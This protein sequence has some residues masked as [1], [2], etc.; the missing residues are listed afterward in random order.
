M[1]TL[2]LSAMSKT[3][4]KK[5]FIFFGLIRMADALKARAADI[6][7]RADEHHA[8]LKESNRALW[9]MIEAARGRISSAPPPGPPPPGGPP[10]PAGPPPGPQQ[11]GAAGPLHIQIPPRTPNNNNNASSSGNA[12]LGS[13]S[14]PRSARGR[15]ESSSSVNGNNG[16][17]TN[18][19]HISSVTGNTEITPVSRNSTPG[20]LN[21]SPNAS[22][23][24]DA[25]PA[26]PST[27]QG[28]RRKSR[29]Q[30]KQRKNRKNRTYKK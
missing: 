15:L 16:N 21:L 18:I 22:P 17:R 10:P 8:A 4:R 3:K 27:P 24:P 30:R 23:D 19:S 1:A 7:R 29:K 14:V 9:D 25:P 28:G 12:T 20:S 6:K 13:S 11:P 5:L 2:K 26:R